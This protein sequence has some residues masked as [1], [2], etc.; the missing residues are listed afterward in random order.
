L[1]LFV[2]RFPRPFAPLGHHE[3][4]KALSRRFPAAGPRC[5][6]YAIEV[7]RGSDGE[8]PSIF[9]R[10]KPLVALAEKF[11]VV[12]RDSREQGID[13][14]EHVLVGAHLRWSVPPDE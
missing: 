3:I 2:Q 7:L 13:G 11:L 1:S 5:L 9:V 14:L 6:D 8:F 4:I 10:M 12:R